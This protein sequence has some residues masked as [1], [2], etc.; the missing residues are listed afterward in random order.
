MK[1]LISML[2][3]LAC[4]QACTKKTSNQLIFGV[5]VEKS[6]KL[7]TL[8][9]DVNNFADS[10]EPIVTLKSNKYWDTVLNPNYQVNHSGMLNY[11][12][13]AD[14]I[15]MRYFISSSLYYKPIKYTLSSNKKLLTIGKFYNR[16]ELA[17]T[18]EFEKIR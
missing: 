7:D 3:V 1:K 9:F 4:L 15:Y 2:L 5:Y 14:T 13:K 18:L 8:D 10:K 17:N 16:R 11:K 12:L 6:L